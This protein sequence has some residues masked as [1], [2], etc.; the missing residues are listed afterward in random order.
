[1]NSSIPHEGW[2]REHYMA[3]VR[4]KIP[5]VNLAIRR[6]RRL[7]VPDWWWGFGELCTYSH[8]DGETGIIHMVHDQA[9]AVIPCAPW[10]WI[11]EDVL[12][13]TN[14][15]APF[16]WSYDTVTITPPWGHDIVRT[17][18]YVTE[19]ACPA[20]ACALETHL[21]TC[22]PTDWMLQCIQV[23]IIFLTTSWAL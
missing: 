18:S 11:Q 14:I 22:V 9:M 16:C 20:E 6:S 3:Q 5:A 19:L 12:T 1:M 2:C 7:K 4:H 21:Q 15:F 23:D 13:D 8:I 17:C 10:H